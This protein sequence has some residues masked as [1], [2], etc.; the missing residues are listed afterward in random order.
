MS[1]FNA[2][3]REQIHLVQSLEADPKA[4]TGLLSHHVQH[5]FNDQKKYLT[6]APKVVEG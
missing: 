1:L 6:D 3:H 2:E 4:G 5:R